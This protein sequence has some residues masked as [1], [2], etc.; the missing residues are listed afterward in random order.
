MPCAETSGAWASVSLKDS[1][2]SLQSILSQ[3]KI[4]YKT[5]L[6]LANHCGHDLVKGV[7]DA[8]VQDCMAYKEITR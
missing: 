8:C 6:V 7:G 5:R 3:R 4:E 2:Y 1:L